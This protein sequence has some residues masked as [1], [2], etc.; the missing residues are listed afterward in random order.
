MRAHAVL[1][2]LPRVF[3]DLLSNKQRLKEVV[4]DVL[5]RY[6]FLA[7]G[8]SVKTRLFRVVGGAVGGLGKSGRLEPDEGTRGIIRD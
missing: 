3:M 1:T 8:R 7:D 6:N 4:G 2:G 5:G